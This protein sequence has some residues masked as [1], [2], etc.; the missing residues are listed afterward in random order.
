M[1][2]IGLGL[3][4]VL[5][6]NDH[7]R[8]QNICGPIFK[9]NIDDPHYPQLLLALE[10]LRS[11]DN[12]RFV[13]VF[14]VLFE[15]TST[16]APLPLQQHS[17]IYSPPRSIQQLQPLSSLDQASYSQHLSPVPIKNEDSTDLVFYDIFG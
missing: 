13:E 9:M 16:N 12:H 2:I 8:I 11:E 4:E 5:K 14:S 6:S 15:Q 1:D 10:K 3:F 7:V 17:Q